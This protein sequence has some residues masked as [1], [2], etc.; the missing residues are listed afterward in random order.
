MFAKLSIGA[1]ALCPMFGASF[2][3]SSAN[4]QCGTQKCFAGGPKGFPRSRAARQS[5]Y[6]RPKVVNEAIMSSISA[7]PARCSMRFPVCLGAFE[8]V[9]NHAGKSDPLRWRGGCS[10]VREGQALSR[11]HGLNGV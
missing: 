3:P 2:A 4:P 9:P 5:G 10:E 6:F 1:T 11:E 7:F 8:N